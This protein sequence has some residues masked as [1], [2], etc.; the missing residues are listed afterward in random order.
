MRYLKS[1][2]LSI[3]FLLGLVKDLTVGFCI[4]LMPFYFIGWIVNQ[5][6]KGV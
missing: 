2:A 6:V 4:F 1:T 3:N 5:W